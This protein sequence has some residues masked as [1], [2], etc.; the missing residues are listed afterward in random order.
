MVGLNHH[1]AD[2]KG[3]RD[4]VVKG[5]DLLAELIDQAAGRAGNH[6]LT[7]HLGQHHK[8][9]GIG[10]A[11]SGGALGQGLQQPAAYLLKHHHPELAAVG[12]TEAVVI[13]HFAAQHRITRAK[14]QPE[15][16]LQHLGDLLALQQLRRR[17]L[18]GRSL[19]AFGVRQ[20]AL[21]A[22]ALEQAH[23]QGR[24]DPEGGEAGIR[25]GAG[26]QIEAAE[27]AQ[28]PA[29]GSDQGIGEQEAHMRRSLHARMVAPA[30]VGQGVA[31]QQGLAQQ[32]RLGAEP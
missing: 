26:L 29:V 19:G 32:D 9:L 6:R 28:H 1:D 10:E 8:K 5:V 13:L 4:R 3:D 2:S 17:S 15:T 24:Q 23:H 12:G 18:L 16:A 11:G 27:V 21:Q 30:R 7:A 22:T 25:E 31:N 14:T 20:Q